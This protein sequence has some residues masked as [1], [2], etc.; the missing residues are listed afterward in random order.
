MEEGKE[1]Q[2]FFLKCRFWNAFL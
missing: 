2:D 1:R